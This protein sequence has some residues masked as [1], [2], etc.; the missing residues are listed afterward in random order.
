MKL[1]I[2]TL[3]VLVHA[4]TLTIVKVKF[5]VFYFSEQTNH[6]YVTL[7]GNNTDYSRIVNEDKSK[8]FVLLRAYLIG[9][10]T[11]RERERKLERD[12]SK[13]SKILN[14]Y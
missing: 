7:F 8:H 3:I 11:R 10:D 12:R 2:K 13:F 1:I 6:D 14:R 5:E 9:I 4:L